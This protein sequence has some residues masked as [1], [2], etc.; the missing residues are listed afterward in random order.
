MH[1]DQFPARSV[2]LRGFRL[3]VKACGLCQTYD[4]LAI[5]PMSL[6]TELAE[7]PMAATPEIDVPVRN[8]LGLALHALT[9][10]QTV[11]LCDRTIRNDQQLRIGVVNAAKI[12]NM[13]K[14]ELLHESV[15]SSD[16]V[17]ADGMSVVWAS[18]ILGE[19]LPERVNGTNLFEKLLKLASE[20]QYR[21][22]LLGAKEDVLC[23]LVRRISMNHDGLV[24]AGS[25]NGYFSDDESAEVARQI[26]ES[27]ADMLFV[28]ITSPKKEVFMARYGSILNVNIV[29]G[30][31]GSF[32]VL[33]GVV[34][35]APVSWQNAGFEWLYRVLQE[36]GRMWRRYLV[37][38]TKF[39][40]LVAK[41]YFS[42]HPKV[43]SN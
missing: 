29:H 34:K 18:K 9:E 16:T 17:V 23:E 24:I 10:D 7:M 40:W 42:P 43:E 27:Q 41:S 38:N 21:V 37:T 35:R 32:D 19:P 1:T 11:A 33:A 2:V 26:A 4:Q 15:T 5:I 30:V 31:G 39:V 8:V 28:G 12:V 20:K 36:P 3:I 25:R 14:S 13:E 22:F 6:R